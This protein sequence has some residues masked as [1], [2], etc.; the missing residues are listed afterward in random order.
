[1]PG[2]IISMHNVLA[3]YTIEREMGRGG[4]AV[5]WLAHQKKQNK[6]ASNRVILK[7]LLLDKIEDWKALDAFERE[8][9]VLS[10]LRHPGIPAFI[11]FVETETP[12]GKRLF[13]VQS[14]IE[15]QDIEALI[16]SGR[17]FT[18]AE[19][20]E[21]AVQIARVLVYLHQFSPPIVHRDIKP[22]NIMVDAQLKVYSLVDF[23]AVKSPENL[24]SYTTTGTVGYMPL[25]QV[26]GKAS[27]ASD[28]YSLG[29]SLIYAL[30]H[31]QPREMKKVN[32]RVDFRPHVNI[33]EGFARV[34]DQMIAPDMQRRYQRAED[35]LADLERL[36]NVRSVSLGWKTH[37]KRHGKALAFA[38]VTLAVIGMCR[39][40][41][42]KEKKA[43]ALPS[44][45]ATEAASGLQP[46]VQELGNYYYDKKKYREAI[47][48]YDRYLAR[49]PN[50]FFERFRRGYAHGKLNHHREA[51]DDFLYIIKNDAA[52]DPVNYY[53][54]GYHYYALGQFSQ[55]EPYLKQAHVLKPANTTIVNYLGLVAMEFKDYAQAIQWFEK[56][57][58]REPNRFL[59]NNLGRAYQGMG[60]YAEALK[61]LDQSLKHDQE[62]VK[63]L[64]LQYARPYRH[65][66]EIYMATG[67]LDKALAASEQALLRSPNYAAVHG[68]Q[69]EIFKQRKQ[70]D[71]A[72][73]SARKACEQKETAFCEWSCP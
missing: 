38:G 60:Q 68:L 56:G 2:G 43:K 71:L 28:I 67:K 45:A 44:P 10:H 64:R 61:A 7:E 4:F 9:R 1:M 30:S 48:Y 39:L 15:G 57:L 16:Q 37:W 24:N 41:Q 5:T 34:I 8:A 23:G 21:M 29:M 55:A 53:N 20:I 14:F 63:Q 32:L 66:T 11:D 13:L 50:A 42:S 17:Y 54:A 36:Q 59:Y 52:P 33:R 69:A 46:S 25:E 31:Q 73:Q 58:K 65:Q 3:D 51:L 70:C 40:N 35:L 27:P 6:G 72:L 47:T 49:V 22:G 26:E 12:Q 18:E 19:V 62:R